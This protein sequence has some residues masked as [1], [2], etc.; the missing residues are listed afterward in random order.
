[1]AIDDLPAQVAL[2]RIDLEEL[3]V[4]PGI[5]TK[6]LNAVKMLFSGDLAG[7]LGAF[8]EWNEEI[9]GDRTLYLFRWVIHD[10]RALAIEYERLSAGQRKHM[11]TDWIG[12]LQTAQQKAQ[13]TR[14]AERIRRIAQ[15]LTH[16]ICEPIPPPDETEELMGIAMNLTDEDVVVLLE[17]YERQK[18]WE[19]NQASV[20]NLFAPTDIQGIEPERALSIL[21]R[22]TSLGLII[23]AQYRTQQLRTNTYPPGGGFFVLASG[24]AFLHSLS[25]TSA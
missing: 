19:R 10:L 16:S 25:K 8:K 23:R 21:G 3:Q 9:V 7:A 15:I 4:T 12:L 22:L 14:A 11:E 17:V 18:R 6:G 20:P 13:A 24:T 5:V 1:M 2:N